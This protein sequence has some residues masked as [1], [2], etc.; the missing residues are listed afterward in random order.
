M[1][2]ETLAAVISVA[3]AVS[4]GLSGLLGHWI[5]RRATSGR[6]ETSEASVLWQQSQDIRQMLLAEKVRAEEQRDRLIDA[7]TT[8]VF[9]VLAEVNTTVVA[10]S[11]SVSEVKA[12]LATVKAELAAVTA[13]AGLVDEVK[14]EL[15]ALRV[16][17]EG[18][19]HAAT[20][21]VTPNP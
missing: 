19:E 4:G 6:V 16:S 9:P 14:A 17:L 21:L 8:Q 20:G 13:V 5:A 15:R 18:G 10:M 3:V 1:S 7:Y 11:N 2:I 12:E